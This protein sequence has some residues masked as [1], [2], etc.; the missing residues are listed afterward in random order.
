MRRSVLLMLGLLA[1]VCVG[2]GEVAC[3]GEYP[4]HLQGL[5]A[6]DDGNLYWSFTTFLV[7]TDGA[8]TPLAKVSVPSHYGDLT[9]HA[10]KVYVAVNLGA[11]NKEPGEAQSWVYVHDAESLALL[12]RHAVP[13]VVHGAGG[14][15]WHGGRF[16]V[17]GGLPPAHTANAVYEYTEAFEFVRR[18]VIESGH[19]EMGIQTVC[20]GRDGTWWFGC[21]GKPA[22]TLCTDDAFALRGVY[23]FNSAVGIARTESDGVFLVGKNRAA[24]KRNSGAAGRVTADEMR[25]RPHADTR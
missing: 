15:E 20:R 10:G 13:D 4:R 18:H 16:F 19:T 5:A 8:G 7:K 6:D 21:Y 25:A 24:G 17:V 14:M 3:P 12:A 22:V 11:F 2:R 23:V 1:T 9:W